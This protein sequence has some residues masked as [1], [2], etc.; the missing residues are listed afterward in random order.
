MPGTCQL[1][2]DSVPADVCRWFP[3][4][5]TFTVS[6][7]APLLDSRRHWERPTVPCTCLLSSCFSGCPLS[8]QIAQKSVWPRTDSFHHLLS[9][10]CPG[11]LRMMGQSPCSYFCTVSSLLLTR[12]PSKEAQSACCALLS[13]CRDEG[14]S[15]SGP[16]SGD[17]ACGTLDIKN[18]PHKSLS[19]ISNP[20]FLCILQ[21]SEVF[22]ES[23]N[24]FPD[25]YL[26]ILYKLTLLWVFQARHSSLPGASDET[27]TLT[28]CNT[29]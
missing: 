28:S 1:A 18:H 29:E 22:Q 10:L 17:M 20:L 21:G 15:T 19:L 2:W 23:C 6:S 3:C 16:S 27:C 25:K 11:K 5:G 26:E 9:I 12:F 14:T 8:I 7:E 13:L 24:W 4:P